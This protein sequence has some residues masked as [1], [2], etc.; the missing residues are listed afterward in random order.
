VNAAEWIAIGGIVVGFLVGA[1]KWVQRVER[2]MAKGL[3]REEHD[4]ICTER[5]ERM[6]QKLD[7]IGED[8]R[9]GITGTH[10]RIDDLYRDL[11]S[12]KVGR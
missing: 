5:S 6:E 8:I 2:H 4:R 11:M 10:K 3:T 12:R 1:A 9:E 7:T